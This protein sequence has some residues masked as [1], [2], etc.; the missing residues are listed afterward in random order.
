MPLKLSAFARPEAPAFLVLFTLDTLARAMLVTVVPLQ[1]YA[2]LGDAQKVSVLY[3]VAGSIGLCGGLSVPYLVNCL[4]LAWRFDLR[5][6]VLV[7]GSLSSGAGTRLEF[8]PRTRAADVRRRH[9]HHLPQSL[10]AR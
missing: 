9:R 10:C 7:S 6:W 4:N 2:L 3:F 8:D 5:I 1:A